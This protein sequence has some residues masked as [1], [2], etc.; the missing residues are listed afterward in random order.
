MASNTKMMK[1]HRNL[2]CD[3]LNVLKYI[4]WPITKKIGHPCFGPKTD[5]F[6][7]LNVTIIKAKQT[8]NILKAFTFTK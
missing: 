7:T 5:I 8:L 1:F 6:V 4:I 2:F 3:P